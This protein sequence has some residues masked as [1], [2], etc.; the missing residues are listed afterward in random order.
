MFDF[1]QTQVF[2]VHEGALRV[3][4]SMITYKHA[5]FTIL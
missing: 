4:K 3:I 2:I 5:K 1:S